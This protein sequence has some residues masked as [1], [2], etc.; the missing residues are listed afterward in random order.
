MAERSYLSIGDVLVL[1]QDEFPEITISKIRFLEA[2]GLLDP[3]RTPSG[4]RKFYPHDLARLRWILIQQR[5]RFL[6]L[7][8]IRDQLDAGVSP[9][10]ELA[11]TGHDEVRP[12]GCAGGATDAGDAGRQDEAPEHE[13]GQPEADER[14]PDERSHRDATGGQSGYE[15]GSNGHNGRDDVRRDPAAASYGELLGA[16]RHD[17]GD[18][19]APSV[20]AGASTETASH[21]GTA[22]RGADAGSGDPPTFGDRPGAVAGEGEPDPEHSGPDA[23]TPDKGPDGSEAEPVVAPEAPAGLDGADGVSLTVDELCAA[24]GFDRAALAELE[25]FGLLE[26]ET[27]GGQ[28]LYDEDALAVAQ[29]AVQFRQFGI[30]ARHLRLYRNGVDRELGLFEQLVA[31]LVHQRDRSAHRQASDTVDRLA[32]LGADLRQTLL[33]RALRDYLR[34][35]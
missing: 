21:D 18:A 33:A 19:G 31:P 29:L 12:D 22:E 15:P 32:A 20:P 9:E 2:Q 26:G 1:L 25:R 7:K 23:D 8:V 34:R 5:D 28:V 13:G 4:Y 11:A 17:G 35:G 27:I 6:P 30:E 10:A 16:P 14:E 3:E 24:A